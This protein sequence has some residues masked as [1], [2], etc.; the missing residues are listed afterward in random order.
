MKAESASMKKIQNGSLCELVNNS[1]QNYIKLHYYVAN[2]LSSFVEALLVLYWT[3][4]VALNIDNLCKKK[5]GVRKSY[6][7]KMIS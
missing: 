2:K 4:A 5:L 6:K 1:P 7:M 3:P